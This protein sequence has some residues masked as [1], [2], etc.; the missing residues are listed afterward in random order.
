MRRHVG[1][2]LSLFT[3]FVCGC[4]PL[5]AIPGAP[6]GDG[7]V[8][9]PGTPGERG[10]VGPEGPAGRYTRI[11]IVSP[12]AT[13]QASGDIL[14]E[15]MDSLPA[16]SAEDPWLIFVEPGVFDLGGEGVRMRP[17][18][19]LKGSG[20]GVTVIRSSAAGEATLQSAEHTQ[21]RD[22][23]VEHVGG[24]ANAVAISTAAE[25]F[26]AHEVEARAHGGTSRTV[27]FE[28]SASQGMGELFDV[29]ASATSSQGD[30][31]GF[32]CEGCAVR[33]T[34]A[35]FTARGG[36]RA[37]GVSVRGGDGVELWDSFATA[38]GSSTPGSE[39]LGVELGGTYGVIVRSDVSAQQAEV[40]AGL[41]LVGANAS[42][43]DSTL[44]GSGGTRGL[45]L[46]TVRGGA[47]SYRVD[48][49]RSTLVGTTHGSEGFAVRI[50]GSLLRGAHV[51][52]EGSV[53]CNGSYDENFNAFPGPSGCP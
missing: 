43:R 3:A 23:T 10:P 34:R 37:V 29:R 24:G 21:L 13:P 1:L 25:D 53:L 7:A 27:A 4:G 38:E 6:G 33:F 35:H 19:H 11:R 5:E 9:I 41:R 18:V 45:A 26:Q 17:H 46:D 28:S 30:V 49:Q 44:L 36:S 47:G 31:L 16:A 48:V 39:S 14:R 15:A 22:I 32:T 12:G 52:G 51:E 40:S 50:G 8:G 20:A 2:C 42:V